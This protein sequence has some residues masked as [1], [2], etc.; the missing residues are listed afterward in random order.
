MARV[1]EICRQNPDIIKY[2]EHPEEICEISTDNGKTWIL[3]TTA[4]AVGL[5]GA[6]YS[7]RKK[8]QPYMVRFLNRKKSDK[9]IMDGPESAIIEAKH[10]EPIPVLP[11]SGA[12]A[13][14]DWIS[15]VKRILSKKQEPASSWIETVKITP[16]A[17]SAVILEEHNK[18]IQTLKDMFDSEP[19]DQDTIR[20][21]Y[22]LA[23]EIIADMTYSFDQRDDV[24]DW[25]QEFGTRLGDKESFAKTLPILPD[26]TI[27][28]DEK[29]DGIVT[30]TDVHEPVLIVDQIRVD[31]MI[32]GAS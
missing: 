10:L 12:Q 6:G 17:V 2:L 13:K 29:N 25:R 23:D 30:L 32:P 9:N 18:K 1:A 21:F 5:F 11:V 16:E 28:S 20:E 26:V 3:L 27:P 7:K 19:T 14:T 31:E 22:H 15:R 4:L 8:I 24:R